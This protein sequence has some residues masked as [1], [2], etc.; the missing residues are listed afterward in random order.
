VRNWKGDGRTS[1]LRGIADWYMKFG[2]QVI[3]IRKSIRATASNSRWPLYIDL[4]TSY[5]PSLMC[6]TDLQELS[7]L[8][9]IEA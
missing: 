6:G 1:H 2:L 3:G 4:F 9:R 5:R 8:V 7:Y